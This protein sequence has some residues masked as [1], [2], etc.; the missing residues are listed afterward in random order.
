MPSK[1]EESDAPSSD[2]LLKAFPEWTQREEEV[3]LEFY[4]DFTAMLVNS[5]LDPELEQA[6]G[7][8]R[9]EYQERQEAFKEDLLMAAELADAAIEL[10]HDRLDV[11][12]RQRSKARKRAATA[13]RTRREK[14]TGKRK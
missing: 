4:Q 3:W 12:K 2:D 9:P 8:L 1:P 6:T 14:R 13:Y 7:N 10:M 11:Q 5:R